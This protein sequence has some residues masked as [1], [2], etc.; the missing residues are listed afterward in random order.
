M[1]ILQRDLK[2]L[3][4][5]KFAGA[6]MWVLHETLGLEETLMI[7]PMDERRGRQ[8]LDEILKGGNFGQYG[9]LPP[10]GRG[11]IGHNVQRICRDLRLLR[12]YPAEALS[13][14]L[15]RTGHYFWRT[16]NRISRKN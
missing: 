15:F 6:M 14:P 8:L 12:H 4:L 10:F 9:K 5:W 3:G 11:A 1:E 2:Y 13:E 7:A 16:L